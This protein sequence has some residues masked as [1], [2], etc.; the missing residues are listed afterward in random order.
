NRAFD[1]GDDGSRLIQSSSAGLNWRHHWHE[2]LATDLYYIYRKADFRGIEREDDVDTAG[3][4]FTY[5][6]RRW[7]DL[8]IG[9]EY[10]ENDST[11][12]GESHRRN[13]CFLEFKLRL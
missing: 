5:E 12:Y 8:S 3:L 9:Y 11:M 6:A 13:A 4:K 1:E 7:L 2:R 10:N